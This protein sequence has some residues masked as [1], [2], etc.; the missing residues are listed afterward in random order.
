LEHFS[1]LYPDE[2]CRSNTWMRPSDTLTSGSTTH[3]L[4]LAGMSQNVVDN[5]SAATT[6]R[7]TGTPNAWILVGLLWLTYLI[8]YTDRQSVFSIFPVL[9]RDLGFTYTQLGLIGSVFIWVYSLCTPFA[10][11]I[12]DRLPRNWLIISSAFL[13]SLT[14]LGIA[15][16]RSVSSFLF[17][18]GMIAVTECI[19]CPAAL[20]LIA[21]WHSGQTRTRA[22]GFHCTAPPVGL[23]LG[24]WFGGWSADHL[25]WRQGFSVLGAVGIVYSV[26]LL[27]TLRRYGSPPKPVAGPSSSPWDIVRA[28]CY[29]AL[30]APYFVFQLMLWM[31]YS[32]LPNFIFERHHLSLEQSGVM[33]TLYLQTSTIAGVLV[34]GFLGDR[35]GKRTRISRFYIVGLGM[36]ISCPFAY[37]LL[38]VDDLSIFKFSACGYG[39][40]VGLLIATSWAAAFDVVDER[41]YSFAAAFMTLTSGVAAGVGVLLA[42]LWRESFVAF[43][44]W[45]AV[46]GAA[47]SLALIWVAA[48]RFD[49]E[50]RVLTQVKGAVG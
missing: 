22:I 43:M 18:R 41:N 8:N 35:L 1:L 37:C 5:P 3:R 15:S 36:L 21:V 7:A 11:R 32:W 33:A 46:I 47:M 2:Y 16:S 12:A 39:F 4:V 19:Y 45:S 27:V 49:Q 30:L 42:G 24:G 6:S 34:G 17:W 13:W 25:G 31:L 26:L 9:R 23:A 38:A 29:L 20:G 48:T 10:G 44:G 50:K 40:F 28:R 14:M